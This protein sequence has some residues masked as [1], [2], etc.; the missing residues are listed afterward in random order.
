[1]KTLTNVIKAFPQVHRT[2]GSRN[3]IPLLM[4]DDLS[5]RDRFSGHGTN[6]RRSRPFGWL[7]LISVFLLALTA[8][9][10]QLQAQMST[11]AAITGT[12]SDNSGAVI[13]GATVTVIDEATNVQITHSTNDTGAFLFSPLPVDSYTLKVSQPGFATYTTNKITLHPTVTATINVQLTTGSVETQI[14]VQASAAQIELASPEVSNSVAGQQVATLPLNGRNFEALAAVMPG[15]QNTSAGSSLG[16]GGRAT[17]NVVSVNGSLASSTVYYVDGIWNENT[18]NMAQTSIMPNPD[19]LEEVRVLQNDF[20]VREGFLGSS[21][22]LL[23][24]KHGSNNFHANAWEYVRNDLLNARNYFSTT[25]PTLKQ[26]IFGYNIGG[27]VWIPRLYNQNREK[28]HFFWSEQWAIIHAGNTLTGITPTTL[29]LAGKFTTAVK[30]PATGAYFPQDSNGDYDI[31]SAI[32]SSALALIK[33]VYPPSNYSKGSNNYINN[34]PTVTDQRDD[35][36]KID[37]SIN[38]MFQLT[39]EYLV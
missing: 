20:S 26:N 30:N 7:S 37:H 32:N 23:Q 28:T 31:S 4:A 1:M 38:K 29:Q 13:A 8:G 27:P 15:V 12:V 21:V 17:S 6:R 18:G 19:S 36:I 25:V 39:A 5:S 10:I 24:T 22:I 14:V 3:A 2:L 35:E 16:T 33:A 34:K 11:T 9:T